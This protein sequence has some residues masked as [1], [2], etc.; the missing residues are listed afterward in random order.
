[1]FKKTRPHRLDFSMESRGDMLFA[2]GL[3]AIIALSLGLTIYMTFFDDE[4]GGGS[5]EDPRYKCMREECGAEFT[6]TNE[7]LGQIMRET[8]MEEDTGF[9]VIPCQV[10]N[11]PESAVAMEKCPACG[12]WFVGEQAEAVYWDGPG[13][14][15]DMPRGFRQKCPKCGVDIIEARK[16]K[17]S[18]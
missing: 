8:E 18:D 11:E 14:A 4:T 16:K 7:Q 10:C 3:V 5:N 2:I 1:M 15:M 13:A 9:G 6:V 17:A 12:H